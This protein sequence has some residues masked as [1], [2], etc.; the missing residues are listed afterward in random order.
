MHSYQCK[1]TR[2]TRNW[3]SRTSPKETHKYTHWCQLKNWHL[4]S[5]STRIKS[6]A[7]IAADLQYTLKGVQGGDQE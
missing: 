4:P 5:D 7:T 3:V 1:D 2:I 6:L